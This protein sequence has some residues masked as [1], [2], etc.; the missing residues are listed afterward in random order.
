MQ[1][2]DAELTK[3]AA[4]AYEFQSNAVAEQTPKWLP[5]SIEVSFHPFKGLDE[6]AKEIWI[7]TVR[8]VV[9][10]LPDKQ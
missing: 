2:S 1:L 5:S 10:N 8:T 9:D 4:K 6:A 7:G 3:L